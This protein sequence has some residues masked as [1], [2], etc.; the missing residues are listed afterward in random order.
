MAAQLLTMRYGRGAELEA[1]K[2][3]MRY[4]STAGYDPAGAVD[5]Q[6]TFVRLSEGRNESWLSGLFASHPP[7]QE[8]VNAN[9]ATAAKLPAGGE[10]GEDRFRLA[11][12]KTRDA[13]PAYDAYDEGRKALAEGKTDEAL[14]L[15][16]KAIGLF[17]NEAH[18]HALR[19]D[20]R[21]TNKQFDM[22]ITNYD[23]AI[24]R[25]KGFFY[26]PLQRGLARYELGQ[27]DVAADDLQ[28][29]IVLLPSAP[30]HYTLGEI[31]ARRGNR[32]AAI[33][34]YQIV[35]KSG[36]EYGRAASEALVRLDL[37]DNPGNYIARRCDAGATGNLVVSVRNETSLAIMGVVVLVTYTDTY[38][39]EQRLQLGIGGRLAP[40]QV[41]SRDTGIGPYRGGSCPAEVVAAEL[42]EST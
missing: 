5:L 8:R 13:K 41:A 28:A 2:Y 3:G 18:F 4:M 16:E 22:A 34:H 9:I 12:Q 11:M 6:R 20:V 1:D 38:G 23:R 21:L 10:R 14:Q 39:R 29:S 24:S 15:A 27:I 25:R 30:A 42:A 31:E 32:A 40:G 26:Y 35:A 17:P 36:G 19:G 37:A 33:A 7:S